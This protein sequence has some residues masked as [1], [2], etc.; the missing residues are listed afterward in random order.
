MTNREI[1]SIFSMMI[2]LAMLGCGH[3]QPAV[4]RADGT[5]AGD[6]PKVSTASPVRKNFAQKTEQPGTIEAFASAPIH[7]KVSGYVKDVLVDIG[8][9]V[10]GPKFDDKGAVIEPGQALAIID[11]PEFVETV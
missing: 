10:Q 11:A 8:D 7:A 6:L 1:I 9:S 2:V 3:Q 5:I 4:P